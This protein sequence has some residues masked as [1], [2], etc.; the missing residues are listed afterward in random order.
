MSTRGGY[1]G[2]VRGT[3]ALDLPSLPSAAPYFPAAHELL[4]I[5]Q[6][7][8]LPA[9]VGESFIRIHQVVRD[10]AVCVVPD[11]SGST[12]AVWGGDPNDKIGAA[13][14]SL[15][16]LLKRSGGGTGLIVPWGS[17]PP[18]ELAV[19]PADVAKR[20]RD[21]NRAL[22]SRVN[23]GGNDLPAALRATATRLPKLRPEQ[24]V[25]VFIPTDGCEPVTQ[26]THDAVAALPSG[27]C[28]LILIDPLNWCT[29]EMEDDWRSVAF[30]SVMRTEDLSVRGVGTQMARL[31]ASS[32]GLSLATTPP[33]IRKSLLTRKKHAS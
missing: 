21:L 11:W 12:F 10:S 32:L 17:A 33:P 16:R 25:C 8:S 6:A 14:E 1:L 20:F 2:P 19:G 30:G 3:S 26:A 7:V 18:T 13:G 23:L 27:S 4:T 22:R 9:F 31:F 15:F 28:H 29:P 5:A 24:T